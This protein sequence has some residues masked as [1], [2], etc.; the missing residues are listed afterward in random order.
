MATT[1]CYMIHHLVFN[2]KAVLQKQNKTRKT[3]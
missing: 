1:N 3:K 2:R